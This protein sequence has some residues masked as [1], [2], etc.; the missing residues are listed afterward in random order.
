MIDGTLRKQRILS[1]VRDPQMAVLFIDFILGYNASMDPVG[2][3]LDAILEA[4]Q[5]TKRHGGDLTIIASI[6]GTEGDPQD[7]KLQTK[8]LKEAGTI[9]FT[10][11]A[12]AAS[13]CV[14][15]LK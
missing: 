10:S 8:L 4:K 14:E 6:C 3:L 2:E 12:K 13:F 1:E 9:F 15:M 11:N 7:M 5:I